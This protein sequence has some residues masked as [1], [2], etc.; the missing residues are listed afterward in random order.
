MNREET[1]KL[2]FQ[3][4]KQWDQL[5]TNRNLKTNGFQHL[6]NAV[7]KHFGGIRQLRDNLNIN[8]HKKPNHY[9]TLEKSLETFKIFLLENNDALKNKTVT[10]LLNEQKLHGLRTAIEKLGGLRKF[11]TEHQLGLVLQNEKWT[12]K[13]INEEL[14]DLHNTGILLTQKNLG[15]IGRNDLLWAISKYGTLSTIKEGLGLPFKRGKYWT[16]EKILEKLKPVVAELGIMPSK[17]FLNAM[18]M[19]DVACAIAKR[20][21]FAKFRDL[22]QTTTSKLYISLDGH[23]LESSYECIVDNVLYKYNIP[24]EVHVKISPEHKFRCDF[25]IGHTYIE[26]TGYTQKNTAYFHRL[27]KKIDLYQALNKDYLIIPKAVF[28][29]RIPEIEK[30]IL[31]VL[32]PILPVT[33]VTDIT[34]ID[35]RPVSYWSDIEN[36]KKELFQ[37]VEK[38]GRMPLD[39]EL[40]NE[41][42]AGLTRGIYTYHENL[43]QLG[44]K[45]NVLVLNRPKGFF[46]YERAISLYT[47]L[48]LKQKRHLSVTELA[49]MKQY[50]I[51]SAIQRKGGGIYTLRTAC[52]LEFHNLDRPSRIKDIHEAI[53]EYAKLCITKGRFLL[54]K[55]LKAV[56]NTLLNYIKTHGGLYKVQE[57]TK[58]PFPYNMQPKGYYSEKEIVDR[59]RKL[60]IEKGYFLTVRET[61]T[62]LSSKVM[63]YIG[64][65]ITFKKLR[66]LTGL[67]FNINKNISRITLEDR[68]NAAIKYTKFCIQHGCLLTMKDLRENGAGKLAGFIT[69]EINI[70]ELH[71]I[72][73]AEHPLLC[74]NTITRKM[75]MKNHSEGVS[76]YKALCKQQKRYLS[77]MDLCAMGHQKLSGLIT[78]YGGF[79]KFRE[80]CNLDF[81]QR[82]R[83]HNYTV[84]EAVAEYK[85]ISKQLSHFASSNDLRILGR[86]MLA[87]AITTVGGYEAIRKATGLNSMKKKAIKKTVTFT[88]EEVLAEFRRLSLERGV[89]FSKNDFLALGAKKM[90]WFIQN[91]GGYRKFQRLSGLSINDMHKPNQKNH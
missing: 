67:E 29:T 17:T 63:S 86:E 24:H 36:I 90:A 40:R 39:R 79:N 6:L 9:W 72:V 15:E 58:L 16:D 89:F 91:N 62:T 88:I 57:Q 43:Y 42:K 2:Y 52:C 66:K 55:E 18:G 46:T 44:K 45:I 71:Q 35:I 59:Y 73:T 1:E 82:A 87:R 37:L 4:Y 7:K 47:R 23:F 8:N 26:I 41:K 25:L 34:G 38:Y 22:L 48:C 14:L 54:E 60:C 11:N 49:K 68:N 56:N 19:N 74:H 83:R 70:R 51:L 31:S 30:N 84:G 76:L 77:D 13:K 10:A 3:L 32:S 20:K 69:R 80:L 21:G 78:R 65:N 50:G 61:S 85:E 5:P 27:Q 12:R 64:G 28:L 53:S 33:S 75:K 81:W